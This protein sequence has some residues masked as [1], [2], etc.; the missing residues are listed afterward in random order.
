MGKSIKAPVGSAYLTALIVAGRA[1]GIE[2]CHTRGHLER[3]HITTTQPAA[4]P[5]T[6]TCVALPRAPSLETSGW[7]LGERDSVTGQT[8]P[9]TTTPRAA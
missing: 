8:H 5:L 7:I 1:C 3:D 4:R 2:G 6:G 9:P